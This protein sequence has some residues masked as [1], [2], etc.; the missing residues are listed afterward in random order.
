MMKQSFLNHDKPI[1]TTMIQAE[2][3]T[4]AI[5]TARNA[6]YDGTDAFGF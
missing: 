6:V 3:I 1:I 5:C 2:N 4:D